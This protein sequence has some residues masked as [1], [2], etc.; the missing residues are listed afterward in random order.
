[1][2][3]T[4]SQHVAAQIAAIRA[5]IVWPDPGSVAP[6]GGVVVGS[7]VAGGVAPGGV[8]AA[9]LAPVG[10]TVADLRAAGGLLAG[11]P[12]DP[13]P[14]HRLTT[15]VL[16]GGLV[17]LRQGTAAGGERLLG[18]ELTERGLKLGLERSYRTLPRLAA[19]PAERIGLVDQ[20]NDIRPWTV[21]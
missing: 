17:M 11:L 1:M 9:G 2:P 20:A 10:L 5:R 6:P 12:L 18:C 13:G 4:S 14:L 19:D 21:I 15:E 8:V 16:R 7:V 3:E